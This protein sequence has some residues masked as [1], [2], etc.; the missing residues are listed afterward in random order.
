MTRVH[1]VILPAVALRGDTGGGRASGESAQGTAVTLFA[2]HTLRARA[3]LPSAAA[4]EL[5]ALFGIGA[6]AARSTLARMARRGALELG[7]QGRHTSYRLTPAAATALARGGRAVVTF[8]DESE[9]WDGWWTLIAF[10]L[11]GEGGGERRVLRGRLRWRGFVPLY[12]ALWVSAQPP[13]P[14]LVDILAAVGPGAITMFR[15]QER[16]VR[17]LTTR[18]PLAVWD[19]ASAAARYQDFV[20]RWAPLRAQ[21]GDPRTPTGD[22]RAAAGVPGLDGAAALRA[23]TEIMDEYRR[24]VVLDP[25]LPASLMP[26]GWLRAQ[27]REIFASIYDGLGPAALGHVR[28][29]VARV[30][31]VAPSCILTHTTVDLAAGMVPQ[32]DADHIPSSPESLDP[33]PTGL[34]P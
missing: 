15:A 16:E 24:F 1:E 5:L 2:D 23:R 17:T 3:W 4:V 33:G 18:S 29:V 25:R 31:G 13:T 26:P 8:V 32:G 21:L 34:A 14:A 19:T 9:A 7:R 28:D 20:C 11:P 10:S 12:D 22:P 30:T 27:A 6:A